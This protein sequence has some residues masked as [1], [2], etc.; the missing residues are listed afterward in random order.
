MD[1]QLPVQGTYCHGHLPAQV[2]LPRI[3][4]TYC[5]SHLVDT[6]LPKLHGIMYLYKL[7][8]V[9]DTHTYKLP[10]VTDTHMY[11][12]HSDTDTHR[13]KLHRDT[14]THLYYELCDTH[15]PVLR[16]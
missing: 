10:S 13:Y 3:T 1:G 8:S 5:T 7:P 11:K 12:L 14:D 15:S 2:T 6:N 9:T 16:M 4:D